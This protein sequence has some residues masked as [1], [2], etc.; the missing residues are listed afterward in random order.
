M[1]IN[2]GYES[3]YVAYEDICKKYDIIKQDDLL[4]VLQDR[5]KILRNK[6]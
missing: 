1:N 2:E 3:L 4:D 6:L 5:G